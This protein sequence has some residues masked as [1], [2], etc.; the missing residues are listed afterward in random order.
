MRKLLLLSIALLSVVGSYATTKKVLFIGNSYTYT[1]NMPLMLQ[2]LTLAMGDTLIYDESDPGGYTMQQHTTNAT[3]IAK[4]F[5][6]HWDVVVIQEQSQMPAFPPSQV[7]TDTYP[8]AARLDSMVHAN[9]SCTQTMFMMTWGHANGD[10]ANCAG[11]PAICTYDGMQQRLRESYMEMGVNNHAVVA[12]VGMAFKIMVDSAYNPWLYI[13][14]SS[15][16][17]VPGS[18]LESCVLYGSIY[19]KR[20]LNCSYLSGLSATDVHLLQRV[21]DKVVFD[22]MALW[23]QNGHY[24]YAGFTHTTTGNTVS[25]TATPTIISGYS[26][27]FGDMTTDTAANPV[28]IYTASGIYTI[29]HTVTTDCF[30][31]TLTDTVH[32]GVTTD[33]SSA[34][35]NNSSRIISLGNNKIKYALSLT[36][37]D[38]IVITDMSG[39]I[40]KHYNAATLPVTDN[41][42]S[43]IYVYRLFTQNGKEMYAGK[44]S[45]Y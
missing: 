5:S 45:V 32:I 39:K 38:E 42:L 43:G 29:S 7:L 37:A 6:Q 20:T 22:S 33:V 40:I 1:N 30:T 26:W 9:D 12:P 34:Q 15:H 18:Y 24:P 36:G 13:A 21:A 25:L 23:Q 44:I 8:Y 14:D 4:I 3:T 27:S 31:E 41:L 2:N 28:H 19:H 10:P 35:I 16:P 11:Y 17:L